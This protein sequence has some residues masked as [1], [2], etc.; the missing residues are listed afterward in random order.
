MCQIGMGKGYLHLKDHDEPMYSDGHEEDVLP[1]TYHRLG[2]RP[3]DETGG[4]ESEWRA[5]A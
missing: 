4:E 2:Q 3:A 5:T 1:S